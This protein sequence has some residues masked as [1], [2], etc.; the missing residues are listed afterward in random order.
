MDARRPALRSLG[1]QCNG[2]LK[3]SGKSGSSF[4]AAFKIPI[5]GGQVFFSGGFVEFDSFICHASAWTK[6]CGLLPKE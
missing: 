5:E 4:C 6:Y 3:L 1:N 2:L